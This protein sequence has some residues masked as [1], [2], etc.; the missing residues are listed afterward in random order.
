MNTYK[1][2][3]I[4]TIAQS[5]IVLVQAETK[6]EATDIVYASE[7]PEDSRWH[8][9]RLIDYGVECIEDLGITD[10]PPHVGIPSSPTS[11]S[12]IFGKRI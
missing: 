1:V 4:R 9:Y 6:E 3:I 8:T 12:I 5:C 11:G 2:E 10:L 7:D